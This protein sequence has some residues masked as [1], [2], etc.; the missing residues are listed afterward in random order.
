MTRKQI[1]D[2]DI[3]AVIDK[4]LAPITDFVTEQKVFNQKIGQ[5]V[6]GSDGTGGM[7]H[8]V[9][10]HDE[11]LTNIEAEQNK[12]TGRKDILVALGGG[13]LGVLFREAINFFSHKG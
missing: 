10:K 11:R 5:T 4:R 13:T 1:T 7:R 6:Y 8:V 3:L 9:E 12:G 2:N